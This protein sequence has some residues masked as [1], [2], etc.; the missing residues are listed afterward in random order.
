MESRA[1]VFGGKE[2]EAPP[3]AAECEQDAKHVQCI[4]RFG[5]SLNVSFGQEVAF[6][7]N[8]YDNGCG[9]YAY[10]Y[11]RARVRSVLLLLLV[12]CSFVIL[13]CGVMVR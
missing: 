8:G 7:E 10:V 13:I 3:C 1:H 9:P 2:F 12:V 6:V 11:A 4:F 5:I